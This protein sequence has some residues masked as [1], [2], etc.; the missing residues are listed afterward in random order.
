[1][2]QTSALLT[3]VARGRTGFT[4]IEL[5][6]VI[7]IIAVLT[8]L[9]LPAVMSARAAARRIQCQNNLHNLGIAMTSVTESSQRFPASAYYSISSA[10]VHANWVVTLLSSLDAAA[11]QREWRFD[12]PA[13][14]PVN[15]A[16]SRMHIPVLAC[17]SDITV[18]PGQGNL[19][20]ACNGGIGWTEPI[21]CP[22]ALHVSSS[23]PFVPLDLNGNGIACPPVTAP[24]GPVTDR[25]M[26][27]HLGL[28]FL[29]NWP[30]GAGTVR[31]H[32]LE[33]IEDGLTQT[34]CLAENVRAGYDP[35]LGA[36][37]ATADPR[38]N[39]FYFSAYVCQNA[40]CSPGNVDYAR[41]N[42]H[43]N[44]PQKNE[45]IN[46]ALTQAEGEAP[47]PSSFHSGGVN[48]LYA[49]GHVSFLNDKIG[50]LVYAS[51][52]SPTGGRLV[53]PLVQPLVNDVP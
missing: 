44:L 25:D 45:S 10:D 6:V 33:S 13:T 35:V 30:I 53:G 12:L 9:L 40:Q 46:S 16:A 20:Y 27:R 24:D 50:G 49:D 22:T 48:V 31:H 11:V 21:D 39:T 17:P 38:R 52:M 1:M 29:E 8:A 14:D 42:D 19:S 4:L 32:R 37:W 34:L 43:V 3:S 18:Q 26:L 36:T 41:A 28:F 51:L 2:K 5:L 47:W 23:P 15:Q 7:S